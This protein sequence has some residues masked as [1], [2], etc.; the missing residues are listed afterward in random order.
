MPR[1]AVAL[2]VAGF[3]A[4]GCADKANPVLPAF[5]DPRPG[6]S[7][8]GSPDATSALTDSAFASEEHD[9]PGDVAAK[10]ANNDSCDLLKQ[11]C[12]NSAYAC[13]PQGGIGRCLVSGQTGPIG[14]C[15]PGVSQNA[16]SSSCT[17]G[18]TCILL[19]G[20]DTL[21]QCL[22]LCAVANPVQCALGSICTLL[23][24]FT[25]VGYCLPA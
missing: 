12:Q 3:V 11:D 24:G 18:T 15:F 14:T 13:Y 2:L 20:S 8:H 4:V 16:S 7:S 23:P 25:A 19:A 22:T 10:D 9:L 1:I 17:R 5:D 6:G 21:G